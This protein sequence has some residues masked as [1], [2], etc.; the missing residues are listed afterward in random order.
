MNLDIAWYLAAGRVLQVSCQ[1]AHKQIE[2]RVDPPIVLL[3]RNQSAA[4]KAPS[5]ARQI[6]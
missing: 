5:L 1:F 4:I 6:F 2:A 3:R